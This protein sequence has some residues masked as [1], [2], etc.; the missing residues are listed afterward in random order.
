MEH[1]R[2]HIGLT[3]SYGNDESSN[4]IDICGRR[5]FNADVDPVEVVS[6]MLY[7]EGRRLCISEALSFP[8]VD[9]RADTPN[10]RDRQRRMGRVSGGISYDKT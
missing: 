2:C 5:A 8:A 3:I 10:I 6:P 4:L 9:C 7:R 1:R